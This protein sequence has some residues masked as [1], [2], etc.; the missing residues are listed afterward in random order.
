MWV[1]LHLPEIPADLALSVVSI[2]P[3]AAIVAAI[4]TPS[5]EISAAVAIKS[6]RVDPP[7]AVIS[8]VRLGVVVQHRYLDGVA[9]F[10]YAVHVLGSIVPRP[11][12]NIAV[13]GPGLP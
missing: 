1:E 3:T 12:A 5:R 2:A 9:A 11:P 8:S 7:G 13:G 6:V 4:P 10:A